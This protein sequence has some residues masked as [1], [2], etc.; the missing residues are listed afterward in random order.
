MCLHSSCDLYFLLYQLKAAGGGGEGRKRIKILY[1]N[2][3]EKE[4]RKGKVQSPSVHC[5]LPPRIVA[6][7]VQILQ[8]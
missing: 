7:E 2:P 6:S 5:I 3:E 8:Q 1:K 4:N